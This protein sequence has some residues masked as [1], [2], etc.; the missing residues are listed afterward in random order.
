[1]RWRHAT[2][3]RVR[4]SARIDAAGHV[5]VG[6]QDDFVYVLALDGTLVSRHN[7]GQ[8]VDATPLLASDGRVVVGTDDGSLYSFTP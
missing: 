6:S 5:Y 4:S 2:G 8:N 3:G 7:L 1:V